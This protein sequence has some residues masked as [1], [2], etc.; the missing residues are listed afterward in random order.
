MCTLVDE[1]ETLIYCIS[2]LALIIPFLVLLY[3]AQQG[4]LNVVALTSTLVVETVLLILILTLVPVYAYVEHDVLKVR[5]AVRRR[6]L[7]SLNEV[8]SVKKLEKVSLRHVLLR[9]LPDGTRVVPLTRKCRNVHLIV[10]RSGRAYLV[11][12]RDEEA[13]R[14]LA[15]SSQDCYTAQH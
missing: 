14:I 15:E 12:L 1:L 2:V 11:N 5:T 7:C 10:T 4:A 13:L 6:V 8:S 3:L 9:R